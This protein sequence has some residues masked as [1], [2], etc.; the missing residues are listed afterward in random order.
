ML[1]SQFVPQ[2]VAVVPTPKMPL[3]P[4]VMT[5]SSELLLVAAHGAGTA[6]K[7]VSP[8]TW[9][10]SDAALSP[11]IVTSASASGPQL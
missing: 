5:V 8:M 6:A 2:S 7:L 10:G 9:I 3:A 1:L 4:N 11:E